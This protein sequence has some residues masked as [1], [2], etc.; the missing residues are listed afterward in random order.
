MYGEGSISSRQGLSVSEFWFC[1]KL[2]CWLRKINTNRKIG[3]RYMTLVLDDRMKWKY[4]NMNASLI[5]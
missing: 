2:A 1:E 5:A 4:V 3:M